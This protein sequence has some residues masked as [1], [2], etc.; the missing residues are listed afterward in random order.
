MLSKHFELRTVSRFSQI[1]I[2]FERPLAFLHL[3]KFKYNQK[4]SQNQ[5]IA[6]KAWEL[7]HCLLKWQCMPAEQS[8]HTLRQYSHFK[9]AALPSEAYRA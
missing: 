1:Q 4:T 6:V 5:L 2:V 3:L 8:L 7:P 9:Q